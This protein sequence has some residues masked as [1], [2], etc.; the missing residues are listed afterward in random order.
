MGGS[1][2]PRNPQQLR[3]G[4]AAANQLPA[5]DVG[6]VCASCP[7]N[8][9]EAGAIDE[10]TGKPLPGV[11]YRIYDIATGDRVA[12]GT[13]NAEGKSPR[14]NIPMP[15]TQLYAVFGTE[16]AMDEAEKKIGELRR[17][18][19]LKANAI[20]DW[21][22]IPAGLDRADFDKRLID[23]AKNGEAVF[24]DRGF[25]GQA[26]RGASGLSR[27]PG[28]IGEA[29]FGDGVEAAAKRFYEPYM[30]EAWQQ[31]QLA[32]GARAATGGESFGAGAAQGLTFGFDE[33]ISAGLNSIFDRRSYEELIDAQRQIMRQKQISNPGAFL[34][35]EI[36]GALPTVFVPVGGAAGN[37]ARAGKGIGGAMRSGA[38][39]G[40]GLGAISGAGHDEG[41]FADRLDGA[42]IGAATGG[43]A[44]AVLS[45]AGVLIARGVSRTRIWARVR[46]QLKKTVVDERKFSDYIFNPEAQ[47]GKDTPFRSLGY[48]REDSSELVEIWRQQ[49]AEKFS[50]GQYTLGRADQYGQR[51]NI[52][53]AL[54]GKGAA[55]GRTSYMNSGWM[56]GPDGSLRLNTPF[57][58]FTK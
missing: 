56:M 55:A 58:G 29:I 16:K 32:T 52:E 47:H 11:G 38:A 10:T 4:L 18:Q 49:A 19:A 1:A 5:S 24:A 57:A 20:K 43:V 9:V 27:L 6:Q 45:G 33:E 31:Y 14:H 36:A 51:I 7:N 50:N 42:A 3:S 23:K 53:I 28:A 44:G 48:S 46:F 25:M 12:A 15:V 2:D 17:E 34:G 40:A 22:G 13:L 26:G 37:A 39:T 30:N 35:G 8:W 21:R 41:G 54:P